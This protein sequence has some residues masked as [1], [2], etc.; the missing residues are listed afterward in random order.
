MSECSA[1]R[2]VQT[3][4]LRTALKHVR[5]RILQTVIILS[6]VCLNSIVFNDLVILSASGK[7]HLTVCDGCTSSV[8]HTDEIMRSRW[9]SS[10]R[11]KFQTPRQSDLLAELIK[12][13]LDSTN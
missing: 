4:T 10:Q 11:T 7:R 5:R 9:S 3:A 12:E 8:S 2:T 13:A 6:S 1:G